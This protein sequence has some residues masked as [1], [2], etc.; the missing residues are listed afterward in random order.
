M[1]FD[2]LL[3]ETGQA[4]VPED[5]QER[6]D[7]SIERYASE[8][9]NEDPRPAQMFGNFIA[10]TLTNRNAVVLD[11]GCGISPKLPYYVE[12]LSLTRYL[13]LEPLTVPVQREYACLTGAVAEKMPLKDASVDAVIFATSFDHIADGKAAMTETRRVL[14]PGGA[15]YMWQGISNPDV[16][17]TSSTLHRL[18]RGAVGV[19][20]VACQ[21]GVIARRMHKRR[22]DLR[23]GRRL[24]AVHERWFTRDEL[25]D[26]WAAWGFVLV[27]HLEPPG[28]ASMYVEARKH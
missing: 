18:N 5:W 14:K 26:A 25:L 3:T 22:R 1:W 20:A 12:Q 23:L 13:G 17:A 10:T 16:L 15:V 6:Q 11:V 28:L 21:A 7:Q 2:E 8:H 4:A 9:Y 27:R 19:L 24:D